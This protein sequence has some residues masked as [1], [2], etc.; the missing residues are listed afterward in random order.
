MFKKTNTQCLNSI[1]T[2]IR[3]NILAQLQQN[4]DWIKHLNMSKGPLRMGTIT[5]L[6]SELNKKDPK[7][8][9]SLIQSDLGISVIRIQ[10]RTIPDIR[11]ITAIPLP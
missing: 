5:L 11:S 8:N 2:D 7:I 9:N 3:I 1:Q 10:N 4:S 6:S